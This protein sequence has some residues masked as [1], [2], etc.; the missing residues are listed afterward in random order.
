MV[1][2]FFAK[3]RHIAAMPFN[4]Y[5]NDNM[6]SWQAQEGFSVVDFLAE[7]PDYFAREAF[8]IHVHS[9]SDGI[10]EFL[11]LQIQLKVARLARLKQ[12]ILGEIHQNKHTDSPAGTESDATD[13]RISNSEVP[14]EEGAF[15]T[16]DGK[17][18]YKS[19]GNIFRIV[20]SPEQLNKYF[21]KKPDHENAS[22][23]ENSTTPSRKADIFDRFLQEPHFFKRSKNPETVPPDASIEAS[24]T[25]DEDLV[26]ETLA[27]ISLAQGNHAEA[28]RI[29]QKLSLLFP[30]KSAYFEAQ[31]EKL[32]D[33]DTKNDA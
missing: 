25:E 24:V 6:P 10:N 16:E 5:P 32:Q 21:D 27:R 28:R 15:L 26:T 11:N 31:I 3:K 12:K 7:A 18:I 29:Y 30:E 8:T 22:G 20:A 33:L 23:K 14:Q 13:S 9:R 1:M 4:N 17:L 19:G 2:C